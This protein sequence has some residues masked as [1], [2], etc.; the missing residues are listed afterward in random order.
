MRCGVI[1]TGL[2]GLLSALGLLRAGHEVTA[3][4]ALSY[5][6]GR[7]T[8]RPCKGFQISTGALHMI[9]HGERG[10]LG[11]LLKA[12]GAGVE[13][14]PS[15]PNGLFRID[16]RDYAFGELPGLLPL[17]EKARFAG[18]LAAQRIDEG[19]ER[20]YREWLS[21]WTSS[22]LI[23]DITDSFCGWTMSVDASG[24]SSREFMAMTRNIDRLMGPGIPM[25]GCKGVTDALV[26]E[27]EGLGGEIRYRDRVNGILVRDGAVEGLLAQERH[28]FDLVVSDIGPKAT[29][30]LCPGL[31]PEYRER[32]E[33]LKE[34]AGIKISVA[35][36]RPMLGHTGVLFTPQAERIDG[37]NEVTNADPSLAPDGMHLLMSHQTLPPGR[38]MKEE[39]RLGLED[40][41]RLFSGFE[42]DCEVLAVQCYRGE[43]P[44]NRAVSGMVLGPETPLKGLYLVGDGIKPQGWMETDGVAAG[45][46][47]A[48]EKIDHGGLGR[49]L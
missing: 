11:R 7:F 44:V 16:G 6:G 10:P 38:D 15:R 3:F 28:P 1:G 34:A 39:I 24:V 47:V 14:T 31:P 21:R 20:P 29:L 27:I 2:G 8:N 12:F 45:V 41:R 36:R 5:P 30:G 42:K 25:G 18:L 32:V 13:I 9:P 48:L 22:P 40:L 33:G 19:D 46:E 37:L 35:C 23:H 49:A 17:K 4:E 26:E 43:W